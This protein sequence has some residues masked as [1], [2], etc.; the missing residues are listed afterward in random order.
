MWWARWRKAELCGFTRIV[1]PDPPSRSE[2]RGLQRHEER[3]VVKEKERGGA[4]VARATYPDPCFRSEKRGLDD[5]GSPAL[6][7]HC[8][9][10][11]R[12]SK[13]SPAISER[14]AGIG[15]HEGR[16]VAD[17][18]ERSGD[19]ALCGTFAPPFAFPVP[20]PFFVFLFS[21]V[22]AVAFRPPPPPSAVFLCSSA[23]SRLGGLF[24]VLLVSF[25]IWGGGGAV[26]CTVL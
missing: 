11:P 19:T 14:E 23:L 22:L 25:F 17:A 12:L 9:A 4:A 7:T 3:R 2:K 8:T 1:C 16:C 15:K 24:C 18:R 26:L 10:S 5:M 13:P 6:W 21:F 20:R